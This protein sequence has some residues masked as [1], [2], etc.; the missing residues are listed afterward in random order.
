[1]IDT[2]TK[3][4]YIYIYIYIY[5]YVYIPGTVCPLF[6]ALAP[7]KQ[8]QTSNQNKGPHL[9][10]R[11]IWV[12]GISTFETGFLGII[13][14]KYPL[15]RAYI[16]LIYIYIYVNHKKCPIP[17]HETGNCQAEV[18]RPML[19]DGRKMMIRAYDAWLEKG[20]CHPAQEIVGPNSRPY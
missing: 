16:G 8:G 4:I 17:G 11:Y 3:G 18:P 5:T 19:M 7:P 2:G 14:H 13:T 20:C 1:M 6:L 12:R 9:G 10:S 15:Y